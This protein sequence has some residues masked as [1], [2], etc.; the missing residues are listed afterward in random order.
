MEAAASY[1]GPLVAPLALYL[2]CLRGGYPRRRF[3]PTPVFTTAK[4]TVQMI[5]KPLFR[6]GQP[7]QPMAKRRCS[8]RTKVRLNRCSTHWATAFAQ[9]FHLLQRSVHLKTSECRER[10]SV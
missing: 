8:N 6:L 5:L 2:P 10:E 1:G 4:T 7:G 9:D 3:P